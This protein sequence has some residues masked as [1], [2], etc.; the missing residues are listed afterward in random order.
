MPENSK[1]LDIAQRIAAAIARTSEPRPTGDAS[2]TNDCKIIGSVPMHLRHLHNLL[3]EVGNEAAAAELAF[4]IKQERFAS[5]HTIFFDA[6]RT[7]VSEP[8]MASSV[9]IH[10]NWDVSVDFGSGDELS[11]LVDLL[12]NTDGDHA[13]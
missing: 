9:C 3:D 13:R 12:A 5:I 1:E 4:R 6:L 7:H 10:E 11:D 8:E 2:M